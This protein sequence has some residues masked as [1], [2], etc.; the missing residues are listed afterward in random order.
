MWVSEG[1]CVTVGVLREDKGQEMEPGD[2]IALPV[3]S[4]GPQGRMGRGGRREGGFTWTGL[5]V[6]VNVLLG[7]LCWARHLG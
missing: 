6:S 2:C 4:R 1:R 7:L 3:G 5:T